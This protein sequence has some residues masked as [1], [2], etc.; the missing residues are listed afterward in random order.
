MMTIHK[1]Y[2][3]SEALEIIR[4]QTATVLCDE[5]EHEVERALQ[6]Q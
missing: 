3:N 2:D 1:L 4:S 6:L 5:G